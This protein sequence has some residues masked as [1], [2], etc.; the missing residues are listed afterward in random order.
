MHYLRHLMPPPTDTIQSTELRCIMTP[1]LNRTRRVLAGLPLIV[2]LSACGTDASPDAPQSPD[3]T[4][5]AEAISPPIVLESPAESGAVPVANR[6][7]SVIQ[8]PAST[9][10]PRKPAV[11]RP[12]RAAKPPAVKPPA[13]SPSSVAPPQDPHAGHNMD[14]MSGHDMSGMDPG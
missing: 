9:A 4:P 12:D 11:A 8:P 7:I 14:D 10:E 13:A 2:A 3:A 5:A 1:I 6:E